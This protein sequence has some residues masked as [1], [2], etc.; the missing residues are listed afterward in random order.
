M[1]ISEIFPFIT[2]ANF[3]DDDTEIK[4][5]AFAILAEVHKALQAAGTKALRTSELIS[6][7]I[8]IKNNKN[9]DAKFALAC[10]LVIQAINVAMAVCCFK[11]QF[12]VTQKITL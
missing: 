12:D 3:G 7:V 8:G 11:S 10:Q 5:T 9:D 4:V 6:H 2:A 1:E